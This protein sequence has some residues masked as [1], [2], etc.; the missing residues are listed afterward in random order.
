MIPFVDLKAQYYSIK[1][2]VDAAISRVLESSQFVFDMRQKSVNG[3]VPCF[4]SSYQAARAVGRVLKYYEI[5]NAAGALR[6]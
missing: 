3:G 2:E 6:G 1:N 5:E 4:T